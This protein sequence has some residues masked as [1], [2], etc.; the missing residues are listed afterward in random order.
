MKFTLLIVLLISTT[1]LQKEVSG[2]YNIVSDSKGDVLKIN[3]NGTFLYEK[4]GASCWLWRDYAG[5]WEIKK[6][7]LILTENRIMYKL[8]K[9]QTKVSKKWKKE[10]KHKFSIINK[11]IISI[12][13]DL[14]EKNTFYKKD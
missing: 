3:E 8:N 11:Q 4:R 10:I 7:I 5:N 9:K 12:E 6:S 1:F 14:T 2:N 13:T